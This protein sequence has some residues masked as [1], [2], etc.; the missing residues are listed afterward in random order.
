M[1]GS[2]SMAATVV[3]LVAAV[4]VT[5]KQRAALI[6]AVANDGQTKAKEGAKEAVS[7]KAISDLIKQIG[8]DSYEVREAAVKRLTAIGEPALKLLQKE[9]AQS[10]DAETRLRADALVQLIGQSRFSFISL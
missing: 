1:P 3:L 6:R 4:L 7:E 9:A 2:Q 8:D 10:K 5:G